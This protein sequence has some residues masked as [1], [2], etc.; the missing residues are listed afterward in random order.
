MKHPSQEDLLGYVL[1]AL[2]A[3]EQRKLQQQIDENPELE[4]ELLRIKSSLLPLDELDGGGPRP[5]LA[6]RTCEAVA[7]YDKVKDELNDQASTDEVPYD[8]A[9]SFDSVIATAIASADVTSESGSTNDLTE[10]GPSDSAENKKVMLPVRDRFLSPSTWTMTDLLAGVAMMAVLAGILFPTISY[11]RFNSRVIAC[12]ENLR[13]V[14]VALLKYSDMNDGRFIAIPESGNLAATGCYAPILKDA[15]LIEDD[16][17]FACA[18]IASKEPPVHIP[19]LTQLSEADVSPEQLS[20]LKRVMG[21]HFG[22]TMGYREGDRYCAPQRMGRTNVV[23][24]ADQPSVNLVGRRSANHSGKGQNCLFEDGRV[25]FVK[26]HTYGPDALFEND[27]GV[28]AP[29]SHPLDNVIAPSHLS[30]NLSV[31]NFVH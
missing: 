26:G 20:Y 23:L 1:G 15:G 13:E 8:R 11:T 31:H 2:D 16:S 6:R 17:V 18:G 5:G 9:S 21:G 3:T 28:V 27:Y 12:Q 22:Y 24:L 10:S 25:E 30:C 14:G 19:G 4:E 29:G 7:S